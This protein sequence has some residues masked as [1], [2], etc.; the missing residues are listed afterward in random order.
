MS[1]SS[2][3]IDQSWMRVVRP[4]MC[5]QRSVRELIDLSSL[6]PGG[7]KD[8]LRRFLSAGIVTKIRHGKKSLYE[9]RLTPLERRF[10]EAVFYAQE[11]LDARRLADECSNQFME[12]VGWIDESVRAIRRAKKRRRDT[13]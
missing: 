9:L 6:S 1:V 8:I 4:L 5:S 11:S 12:R 13:T 3:L 2:F 10:L 7:V